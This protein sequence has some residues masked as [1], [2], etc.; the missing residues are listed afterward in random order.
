MKSEEEVRWSEVFSPAY[1]RKSLLEWGR[2]AEQHC[3]AQLEVLQIAFP[4]SLRLDIP[5]LPCPPLARSGIAWSSSRAGGYHWSQV[6]GWGAAG[7]PTVLA[8]PAPSPAAP[9]SDCCR[10]AFLWKGGCDTN[11]A[12]RV[13]EGTA[14]GTCSQLEMCILFSPAVAGTSAADCQSLEFLRF[15]SEG[16]FWHYELIMSGEVIST[17]MPLGVILYL[18]D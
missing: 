16:S 8:P 6:A 13:R 12:R 4:A 7:R 10:A 2:K 14:A 11:N 9:D 18:N 1:I 17:H 5:L 15:F 3:F